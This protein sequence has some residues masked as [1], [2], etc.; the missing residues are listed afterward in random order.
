MES[1]G[2][3]GCFGWFGY[4]K[5]AHAI[6]ERVGFEIWELRLMVGFTLCGLVYFLFA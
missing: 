1:S 2:N 4:C 5:M 3:I 6:T